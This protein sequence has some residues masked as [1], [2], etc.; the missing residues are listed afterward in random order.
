MP[1]HLL[2]SI[3]VGKPFVRTA[4]VLVLLSHERTLHFQQLQGFLDRAARIVQFGAKAIYV[5]P[6]LLSKHAEHVFHHLRGGKSGAN[7]II[8]NLIVFAS[9][10]QD[11]IR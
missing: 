7:K 6:F 4:E 5:Q 1:G 8:L 2:G 9:I 3:Q 10:Q 11:A